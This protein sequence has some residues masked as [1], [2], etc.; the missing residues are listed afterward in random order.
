MR[1]SPIN[2]RENPSIVNEIEK[3]ADKIF[4]EDQRAL[5]KHTDKL[6][7]GLMIF[8]WIFGVVIAIFISPKTWAG[9]FSS[10]HIH[11]W[12][13]IFLGGL[14]AI[15]PILLGILRPGEVYTRH[16]I[17][18]GQMLYSALLIHL[19]GGRIETHFHVFGSLAFLAFYRDWKVLIPATVVVAVDHFARGVYWPESVF[20]VL[21]ASPYRWMEHAAW[22]IFE[23]IFLVRSC[24]YGVKE[25]KSIATHTAQ[26][27]IKN[28]ELSL[29]ENELTELNNSLDNKVAERTKELTA[30]NEKLQET[31]LQLV[32]SE[33]L[34]SI[35][36]L[37][38]GVAHEIN[39]PV[40]FINNNMEI[41]GQYV[42]DY[43]TIIEMVDKLKSTE[44][45]ESTKTI[46]EEIATFEKKVNL[47][48]IKGDINNLLRHTQKGIERIRKIVMD[49][50]TFSRA[51]TDISDAVK[52]E[53]V[54]DSILSIVDNELKYKAELKK[55]YGDTPLI[56]GSPQ[57]LGQVFI[58]LMVNAVQ[59]MEKKGKIE[60]KTYGEGEFVCV[61]V[62]D[63]G[64]GIDEKNLK[65]IFDPFF[66]TKPIGQGTGLG[67]S[68][69]YEII[70][71]HQGDIKVR[72]KIGEGTTFVVML[73][74]GEPAA[75]VI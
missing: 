68:V 39:N 50:R 17:A 71:K 53:E 42:A 18:T 2:K 48:Y 49:L 28:A 16:I 62:S 67:L 23:D 10:I 20:G 59:A 8:Q 26:L 70:K 65:K 57:L 43:S 40:G 5:A 69:S 47:D 45:A 22:V 25:M 4:K 13:A 24:L 6:F 60:I 1:I 74:K 9:E 38:A 19:M 64:K 31:Q 21:T 32:Q 55:T 51:D 14:I 72:S 29:R 54:I 58:N 27:Q 75:V 35:G 11:I 12:V 37:A 44:S 66:T 15:F 46:I 33:R 41:L 3:I 56:K 30:S 52:I 63:D 7:V 36:Q 61:E 73:P 34:A